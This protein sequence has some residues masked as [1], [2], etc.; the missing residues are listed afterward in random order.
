M[1]NF[2]E[3]LTISFEVSLFPSFF[4]FKTYTKEKVLL[5]YKYC[6]QILI[7]RKRYARNN[8][9][10]RGCILAKEPDECFFSVIKLHQFKAIILKH[11]IL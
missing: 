2:S 4:I 10:K 7:I 6:F 3:L 5:L 1:P 8:C 9:Q 11:L